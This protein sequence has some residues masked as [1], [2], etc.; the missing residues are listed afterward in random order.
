MYTI[1]ENVAVRAIA[2]AAPTRVLD[3]EVFAE[4]VVDRRYRRRIKYTGIK[5]RRAVTGRQ[6]TSDLASI[7]AEKVLDK[8][9]WERDSVQVLIFITQSPDMY[10][11]STAMLIQTKLG[12]SQSLM[13][14]DVNLGCSGFSSG[15][16]IMAGILS[17]TKSRGLLLM[18]DCQ[19]YAPGT[20]YNSDYILFGDGGAAVAMEYDKTAESM[21]TF[22][23]TDGSRFKALCSCA[24][25]HIMDGNEIVLFSLNEVV[26]DINAFHEYYGINRENVDYYALHQAQKI[27]IDGIASN[28]KLPKEKVLEAYQMYGNTSSASIPFALCA[29]TEKFD[30][31]ILK[32]FGCGFG[33]GLAWSGILF[34]VPADMI[35]PIIESDYTYPDLFK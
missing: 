17:Q 15:L 1:Y 21:K 2:S 35:I 31:K 27:I 13:A 5:K 22:Q 8:L 10:A 33:I 7:A 19:H 3:N 29:N 18:G 25:G 32:I 34:D 23:M 12:L 30:K 28:C 20:E 16:Q 9:R 24:Q 11:P 26:N 6:R 14:F 4:S